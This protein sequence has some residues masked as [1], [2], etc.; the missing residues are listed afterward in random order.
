MGT[1][2]ESPLLRTPITTQLNS[3]QR[4]T[5]KETCIFCLR[6]LSTKYHHHFHNLENLIKKTPL[7]SSFYTWGTWRQDSPTFMQLESWRDDVDTAC[8]TPESALSTV[9]LSEGHIQLM[10]IRKQ[11][12]WMVIFLEEWVSSSTQWCWKASTTSLL[13]QSQHF[14]PCHPHGP[15]PNSKVSSASASLQPQRRPSGSFWRY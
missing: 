12:W 1:R 9:M 6:C 14:D 11:Y 8:L 15:P 13:L 10:G 7:C 3:C 2:G 5:I 4:P